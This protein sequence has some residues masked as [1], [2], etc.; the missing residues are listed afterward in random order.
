MPKGD[1]LIT[2]EVDGTG[3]GTMPNFPTEHRIL[4]ENFIG[5]LRKPSCQVT[6]LLRGGN[7][8]LQK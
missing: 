1:L 3:S 6:S 7:K 2:T 4:I 8:V 5:D